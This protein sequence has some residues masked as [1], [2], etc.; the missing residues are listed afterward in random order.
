MDKE[1][2][3]INY[4][5]KIARIVLKTILILFLFV[6]FVFILVLTPPVQR[7]L[8]TKVEGYLEN[9][10]KTR[11][12][13]GTISFGLS[14]NIN[15]K[16]VYLEDRNKD[17][18]LAGGLVKAHLNFMR[19]FSNEVEIKDLELQN[20]TAKIKRSLPDTSYNF[21]FIVDAF[22]TPK[23]STD[24]S[25]AAPMKLN[26]SDIA[27][28]N[29]KLKYID[30][31]SGSDMFVHIGNFS[32]TFDTLDPYIQHF[33]I[34]T[35]IARNV[36]V[37]V[38][39]SKPLYNTETLSKDLSDATT[40]VAMKLNL[41]TID[42]SKIS[43]Q[44]DNDVS[45]FYTSINIGQLKT[46]EKL[47]DLVNNKIH[48]D[49]AS[50]SNSKF[51]VRLG[52]KEQA[53]VVEKE[54]EQEIVAQ[55]K[56]GWDFKIGNLKLDNNFIQ[57]D[58]DNNA[59]LSHGMDFSH[60]RTDSLNFHV[61]NFVMNIDS[62]GGKIT[63]GSFREKSGFVLE[64]F[65]GD[66][67]YAQKETYFKD[68]LIK[69]SGSEIKR[70][71]AFKYASY[72]AFM[73]DMA[74][75]ILDVEIIDS[76][77]QVKDILAFAPQLRSNPALSNPNDIWYLNIVGNGTLNRL[78]LENLRFDGLSNTRLNASGTLVGLTNPQHAGGNF[79]IYQLHTNQ[80]DI[81]LFTG[82][83]LSNAQMN[84][85]EE[86]DISGTVIGNAGSVNTNLNVN[87]SSGFIAVK[88]K[89]N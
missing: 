84:L 72:D 85:P 15:L 80:T 22:T 46:T 76:R 50:V 39:Q 32:A 56:A 5:R 30:V 68:L 3:A 52:K 62:V 13:I 69:T 35:I 60:L 64:E 28:N 8:T 41:G 27:L 33:D 65:H 70:N 59:K 24:T 6:C 43:I 54:V 42:L 58:N 45:A 77:V 23:S 66:V 87:T 17:T 53:R 40:P 26:I 73:K 74:S 67:L 37:R 9:K 1:K 14:G 57:F 61:E 21:Q 79:T 75:T 55:K 47:I 78:N 49:Q 36:T 31:V 88:G 4:P 16:D 38:K 48:L 10:L 82:Q 7:F 29:I 18:L 11:V 89:F 19:L 83:R 63:K 12:E 34:P 71:A 44:F 25:S 51:V 86:F 20:I 2:K 81:A